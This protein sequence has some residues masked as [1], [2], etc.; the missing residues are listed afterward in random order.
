MPLI[1]NNLYLIFP[2]STL[3]VERLILYS[4]SNHVLQRGFGQ[5]L[6]DFVSNVASRTNDSCKKIGSNCN[7]SYRGIPTMTPTEETIKIQMYVDEFG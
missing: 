6:H 1:D 5:N 3:F 2:G 7:F 4:E